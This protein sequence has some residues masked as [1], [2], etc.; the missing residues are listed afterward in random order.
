MQKREKMVVRRSGVEMVPVNRERWWRASRT[1]WATKSAERPV[2]RASMARER[3]A[4]VL[5][6]AV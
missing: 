3:A 6:R 1:S 4:E 5:R 2:V